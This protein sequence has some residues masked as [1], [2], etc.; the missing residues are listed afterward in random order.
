M[1]DRWEVL[2]DEPG[3]VGRRLNGGKRKQENITQGL[4]RNKWFAKR[5]GST[6]LFSKESFALYRRQFQI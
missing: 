6:Q 5:K 1:T 2:L 3:V 4:K